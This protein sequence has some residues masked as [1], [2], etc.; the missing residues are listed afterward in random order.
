MTASRRS[1]GSFPCSQQQTR[2]S[3]SLL[4]NAGP[5]LFQN[6]SGIPSTPAAFPL[7]IC[8]MA[9]I[10]SCI[11]GSLS[12]STLTGSWGMRRSVESWTTRS[13]LKSSWKCSDQRLR[14][15]VLSLRSARPSTLRKGLSAW[16]VGPYTA[17]RAS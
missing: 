17:L 13:A 12:S 6:S 3:W 5:P 8:S 9:L 16:C 15:D 4:C 7:F 1:L 11:E 14:I 2:S 10:S